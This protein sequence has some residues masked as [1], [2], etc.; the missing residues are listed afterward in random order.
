MGAVEPFGTKIRLLGAI[1]VDVVAAR[2]QRVVQP[3][4]L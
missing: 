1:V 4:R 3:W 2:N